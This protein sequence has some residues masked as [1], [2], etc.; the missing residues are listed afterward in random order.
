MLPTREEVDKQ[1]M[2]KLEDIFASLDDFNKEFTYLQQN[3]DVF[4][5]YEGKLSDKNS[6]LQ[7]LNLES[8]L[9]ERLERA[10][11]YSHLLRDQDTAN[12]ENNS[13][14]NKMD[15]LA[16]KFS[17]STSFILPEITDLSSEYL[18]DLLNDDSFKKYH[19]TLKE[20]IRTKQHILSK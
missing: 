8:E 19:L 11:V 18:Q 10:Y 15:I 16:T 1:Y 5:K 3:V 12:N 17:S 14:A 13:R 4:S 20:I 9:S 6:L 2:W 7:L